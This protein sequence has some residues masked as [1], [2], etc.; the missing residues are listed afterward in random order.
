MSFAKTDEQFTDKQKQ[1]YQR[2][3][4]LAFDGNE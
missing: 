4:K 3:R 2:H 1:E